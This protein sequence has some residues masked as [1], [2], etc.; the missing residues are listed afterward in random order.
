VSIDVQQTA[1]CFPPNWHR[2]SKDKIK[3]AHHYS[4]LYEA[5]THT[6]TP[7]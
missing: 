4:L 6:C 7:N 2:P 3:P 5:L 1:L